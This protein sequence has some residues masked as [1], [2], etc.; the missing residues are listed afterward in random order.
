[1]SS[2]TLRPERALCML[3]TRS[4]PDAPRSCCRPDRPLGHVPRAEGTAIRLLLVGRSWSCPASALQMV[5]RVVRVVNDTKVKRGEYHPQLT[6]RERLVT[7][8][9]NSNPERDRNGVQHVVTGAYG[10]LDGGRY[11]CR[12]ERSMGPQRH[13]S[14]GEGGPRAVVDPGS[15]TRHPV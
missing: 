11:G 2:V 4:P 15:H 12:P 3:I 1:M 13:A 5:R 7:L 6:E 14:G 9:P 8:R 10:A